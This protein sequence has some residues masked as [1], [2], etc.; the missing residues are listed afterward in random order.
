MN[1]N[2]VVELEQINKDLEYI[3]SY[4]EK[5][6]ALKQ[7][8][9]E[10]SESNNETL[11]KTLEEKNKEITNLLT[12]L[13]E[14]QQ[15]SEGNRQIINKLLNDISHYQKDIDWYKRTYEKRSLLGTIREK[16]FRRH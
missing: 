13:Q 7:K 3:R 6:M 16:L 14:I 11:K 5:E 2:E 12:K 15:A 4:L 1:V 10:K 9:F 8:A